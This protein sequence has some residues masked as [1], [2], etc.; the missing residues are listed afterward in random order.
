[1]CADDLIGPELGCCDA[2]LAVLLAEANRVHRVQLGHWRYR[3]HPPSAN[4]VETYQG[5]LQRNPVGAHRALLQSILRGAWW[6]PD[7]VEMVMS[8]SPDAFTFFVTRIFRLPGLSGNRNTEQ[9][10][11][12]RVIIND[13]IATHGM[14]WYRNHS[15][16]TDGFAP[17]PVVAI[18]Y[19]H[20]R[21]VKARQGEAMHSAAS[22]LFSTPEAN[23]TQLPPHLA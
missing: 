13:A 2:C 18:G 12:A 3:A 21:I 5:D 10:P 14:K 22:Q 4:A 17:W 23:G 11:R 16:T 1:M 9:L 19:E 20:R 15:I 7:P 8:L 6:K